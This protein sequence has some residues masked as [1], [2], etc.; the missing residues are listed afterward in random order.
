[1]LLL[2]AQEK[3][4][5]ENRSSGGKRYRKGDFFLLKNTD[6]KKSPRLIS[7]SLLSIILDFPSWSAFAVCQ[8][9]A[10][11]LFFIGRNKNKN[12]VWYDLCL[13]GNDDPLGSS[14]VTVYWVLQDS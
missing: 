6:F 1:V 5:E 11:H 13:T 7:I 12:I 3:N 8:D 9:K 4:W 14:P 2:L 10:V